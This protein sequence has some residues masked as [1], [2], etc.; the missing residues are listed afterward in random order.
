MQVFESLFEQSYGTQKGIDP[1]FRAT[2]KRN[3]FMQGLSLKWQEKFYLRLRL[4]VMLCT[5][6]EAQRSKSDSLQKCTRGNLSVRFPLLARSLL[7]VARRTVAPM[8]RG[9]RVLP[10][11]VPSCVAS[12]VMGQGIFHVRAQWASLLQ[13]H[14]VAV[15]LF[16]VTAAA[17][18]RMLSSVGFSKHTLM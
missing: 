4:S 1:A 14:E 18:S 10:G 13:R 6:P 17:E 2:L 5:R 11:T 3:L 9:R 7:P 15:Q 16:A 12:S 8:L